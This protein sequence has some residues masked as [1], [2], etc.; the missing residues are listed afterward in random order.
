MTNLLCHKS[1]VDD[2]E[3]I[4]TLEEKELATTKGDFDKLWASLRARCEESKAY[5]PSLST[6]RTA[7]VTWSLT[8]QESK[9][10]SKNIL[11]S[12]ANLETNKR[13][14]VMKGT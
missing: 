7:L 3:V 12:F 9:W 11:L 14:L 1:K 4:Q 10:N 13:F 6:I 5:N 2:K 8:K